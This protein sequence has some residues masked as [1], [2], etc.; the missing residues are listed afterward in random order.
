MLVKRIEK[1]SV[2][3]TNIDSRQ[4]NKRKLL[5]KYPRLSNNESNTKKVKS[6]K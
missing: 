1:A 6:K 2:I 4:E 5:E 3:S